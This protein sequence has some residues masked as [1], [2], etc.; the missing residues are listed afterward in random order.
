VL[1]GGLA[2]ELLRRN[3][4]AANVVRGLSDEQLGRSAPMPLIGGAPV[5]ARRMIENVLIGHLQEHAG[6]IRSA[7]GA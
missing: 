3:G 5:S 6:S 1:A 4:A 2:E 7:L